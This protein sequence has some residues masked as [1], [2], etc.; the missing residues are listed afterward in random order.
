M[1]SR[2]VILLTIAAA[3]KLWWI[4]EQ[5]C[6]SLM[7]CHPMFQELLGLTGMSVR[8]LTTAMLWYGAPSKK[9]T[10]LY[11]RAFRCVSGS[12]SVYN[13]WGAENTQG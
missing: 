1:V 5:P 9:P 6:N 11:S 13:L 10:W 3:R 4:L 8:R 7:E 2:V 12:G